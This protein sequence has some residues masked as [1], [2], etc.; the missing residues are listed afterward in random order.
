M[1]IY[2]QCIIAAIVKIRI[3]IMLDSGASKIYHS[4][5]PTKFIFQHNLSNRHLYLFWGKWSNFGSLCYL[6]LLHV[7]TLYE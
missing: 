2:E 7:N 6:V 5:S 3:S 4:I 1:G